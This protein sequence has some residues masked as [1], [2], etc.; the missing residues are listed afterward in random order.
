MILPLSEFSSQD[1]ELVE[2]IKRIGINVC[3][4]F[5]SGKL[6]FI[7]FVFFLVET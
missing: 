4:E 3:P 2:F 6:E 1:A 5:I 7:F